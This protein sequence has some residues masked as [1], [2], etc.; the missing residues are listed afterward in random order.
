[1]EIRRPTQPAES[2]EPT[3]AYS[4]DGV[5]VTLIHWMLSLTPTERLAAAQDMIDTVWMLREGSEA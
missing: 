4:E 1:M 5:D 3:D 2:I